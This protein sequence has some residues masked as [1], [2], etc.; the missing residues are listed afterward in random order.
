VTLVRALKPWWRGSSDPDGALLAAAQRGDQRAFD[1]LRRIH[2]LP[3]RG[4]VARRVGPDAADDLAQ[5]IW[6]ACWQA[7]H[8]YAGRSRFKA[9]LYGIAVH[10]CADCLRA[11]AQEARRQEVAQQEAVQQ[12]LRETADEYHTIELRQAI[13]EALKSVPDEQRE[14]LELY[15]YASLTLAEIAQALGRNLNTVKYQFYRAH[16][17]VEKELKAEDIQAS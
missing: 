13:Q 5:D 16:T 8:R 11:R 3:L 14:V 15:Y 12:E 7:L 10:K 6:L 9:W 4:F 2:E 17:H 1:A